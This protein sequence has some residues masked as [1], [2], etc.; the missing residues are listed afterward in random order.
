MVEYMY[1]AVITKREGGGYELQFIDFVNVTG[2]GDN[3]FDVVENAKTALLVYFVERGDVP[4]PAS[5]QLGLPEPG[6]V[7]RTMV[8]VTVPD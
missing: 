3:L 8:Q 2:T 4:P 7:A 5:S 6:E 1:P